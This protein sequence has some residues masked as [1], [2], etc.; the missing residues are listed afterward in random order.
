MLLTLLAASPALLTSPLI[1]GTG[2]EWPGWRGPGANGVGVGSPPT[3]WSEGNNVKW[4]V[5][6][7]G[8][9]TSSPVVWGDRVFLTTAIPTET[10]PKEEEAESGGGGRRGGFGGRSMSVPIVEQEF[11]VLA[12]DRADGSEIW[13]RTA[14]TQ[15]PHQGTH[16]DG[17]YATPTLVTDGEFVCASFGSY[18]IYTFTFDGEPVW[19]K[20][21]GDMDIA[22]G[23]GEGSSPVLHGDSLVINWDHSGDSF[24]VALNRKTGD[25]IWRKERDAVTTWVSPMLVESKGGPLVVIGGAKTIA[26]RVSDGEEAWS[27]DSSAPAPVEEEKDDAADEDEGEEEDDEGEEEEPAPRRRA[28][29]GT[30]GGSRGGSSGGMPRSGVVTSPVVHNGI[31]LYSTGSRRGSFRAL[32]LSEASGVVESAL[33]T[34]EGDTP[35]IPSPIAYDGIFYSLK[36][37]SGLISAYSVETGERLYG[38]ERMVGLTDAYASPIAAGGNIFFVGRDGTT[39]VV[40]AGSEYKSVAVNELDETID[41]SPALAGDQLFLRGTSHLYCIAKTD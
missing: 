8:K 16:R 39:E 1:N 38:P 40:A 9:G 35:H 28:W 18:G 23:F 22:G 41:A 4:K 31:L 26:Y 32:K 2:D 34:S 25:E 33:W 11:V 17:S 29:P 30:S 19:N 15:M 20:D 27:Y 13:R 36:S 5:A 10:A 6:L 24:V 37:N 12:L 7:P 21:L 14:S 3:E